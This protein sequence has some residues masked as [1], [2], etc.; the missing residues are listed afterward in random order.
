MIPRIETLSAADVLG[1]TEARHP[2]DV[3]NGLYSA[4]VKLRRLVKSEGLTRADVDRR[5]NPDG[6]DAVA[7]TITQMLTP[8]TP[9]HPGLGH[10]NMW[11]S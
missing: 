5:F 3:E 10:L 9:A 8:W 6:C 7:V 2:A 11:R 1:R 4:A